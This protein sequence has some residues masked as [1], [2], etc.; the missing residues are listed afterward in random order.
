MIASGGG[1]PWILL[2]DYNDLADLSIGIHGM[3]RADCWV[4]ELVEEKTYRSL[5]SL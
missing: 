1:I 3:P 2:E 5:M 4:T